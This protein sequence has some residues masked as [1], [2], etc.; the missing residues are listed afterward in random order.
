MIE[1]TN[2]AE[3]LSNDRVTLFEFWKR[4]P[5]IKVVDRTL[6]DF[7]DQQVRRLILGILRQ[8]IEEESSNEESDKRIRHALN[9]QEL[10]ERVNEQLEE[11][12][13]LPNIY[14][15]LQKLQDSDFIEAA[16]ILRE[17]K[18][19]VAYFGRTAKLFIFEDMSHIDSK[20]PCPT[21]KKNLSD[22]ASHFAP[23]VSSKELFALLQE[24]HDLSSRLLPAGIAWI[25][26]HEDLVTKYDLDLEMLVRFLWDLGSATPRIVEIRSRLAELLNFPIS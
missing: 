19:D 24:Y 26:K 7:T 14:F 1:A 5:A 13:K 17:G 23:K 9:A 11:K 15:H 6:L 12:V 3:S 22:L 8:G 16:A 4:I 18:H 21:L 20:E 25:E 2:K 10:L